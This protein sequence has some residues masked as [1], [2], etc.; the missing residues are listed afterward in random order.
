[1][2]RFLFIYGELNGGGAER[3]LLDILNNFD[4]AHCQVDLLQINGGGLL[5]EELPSQINVI[6]AWRGYSMS[7]R[8]AL[9]LSKNFGI[10]TLLKVGV[11]R[12]IPGKH[13][14]VG[15]SF[16]EGMPVKV[17]S[18][19]TQYSDRNYS[20]VHCDLDKFPYEANLF[21]GK[22]EILAYEK[23]TA[24]ICV[25]KDTARAFRHRFS[26]LK[27]ATKV[28]YNP[29]DI[30]K[31]E[32]LSKVYS[33]DN[34]QFTV[35]VCGRLTSQK[36]VDRVFR[37]A[38]MMK[39][40]NLPIKFQLIGGGELM[41]E[42]KLMCEE[43]QVDDIVEFVGFVRNPYPYIKAADVLLSTSCAEGFSLVICEAMALGVPVI[44]TKTSGPVEILEQ[45]TY[46]LLCDHDDESIFQAVKKMYFN[47]EL[48]NEYGMKGAERVK[49]FSVENT[50][51][52]IWEL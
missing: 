6:E 2:K 29:I 3:V 30:K 32:R 42:L 25:A 49:K 12:V 26:E 18:L 40:R 14:D 36:R 5:L 37:V 13:Y 23:M 22:A 27:V 38:K 17:H 16:L 8:L 31:I 4:Y 43:L 34:G 35:A 47:A 11:E 10:D 9:S 44:S 41:G 51:T 7:Y 46:G 33:V 28:I 45:N 21:R 39:A 1:M 24:V 52:E 50:M 19:I 48:R 20:W 15:I